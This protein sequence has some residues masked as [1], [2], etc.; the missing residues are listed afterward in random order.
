MCILFSEYERVFPE[1][2]TMTEA[3]EF[4]RLLAGLGYLPKFQHF[5]LKRAMELIDFDELQR[6]IRYLKSIALAIAYRPTDYNQEFVTDVNYLAERYIS[7]DEDF[8]YN[9]DPGWLL[10][11]RDIYDGFRVSH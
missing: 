1:Q 7:N 9:Q 5:K 2:F 8:E 11:L 10:E 3:F 6:G 4:G